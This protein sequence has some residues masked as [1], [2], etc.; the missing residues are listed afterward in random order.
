[1][2]GPKREPALYIGFIGAVL[3][4]LS[5]HLP[6]LTAGV[7]AAI[8]AFLTA[9]V[10]A[11][12]TRP[13]TPALATGVLTAAVALVGQYGVHLSGSAVANLTAVL[14]AGLALAGVRPQVVPVDGGGGAPPA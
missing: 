6:H 1:M 2:N 12:R 13:V 7:S 9:C 4:A 5:G 3:V 11:W 10:V 14:L 8:V